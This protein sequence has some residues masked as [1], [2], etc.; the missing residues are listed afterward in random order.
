MIYTFYNEFVNNLFP[1]DVFKLCFVALSLE[2]LSI[3]LKDYLRVE[4]SKI[5]ESTDSDISQRLFKSQARTYQMAELFSLRPDA[6][7][8]TKTRKIL[9]RV[10]RSYLE[11][12]VKELRFKN[13]TIPVSIFIKRY[14][15]VVKSL[16]NEFPEL[17]A[18]IEANKFL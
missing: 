17:C 5:K 14:Q 4:F 12:V 2:S 8:P 10:L 16:S 11:T 15:I 18:R 6:D 7:S 13:I 3:E 1:F 9:R